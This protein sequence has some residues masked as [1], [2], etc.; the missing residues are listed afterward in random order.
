MG[1]VGLT[2]APPNEYGVLDHTVA[3]PSGEVTGSPTATA[4][5]WSSRSAASRA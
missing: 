5:R 3:L 4:A 2:F 1:R